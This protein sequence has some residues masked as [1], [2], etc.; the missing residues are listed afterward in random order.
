MIVAG[1]PAALRK[2]PV[3][4]GRIRRQANAAS[5]GA[6]AALIFDRWL[7][8]SLPG[9]S[10]KCHALAALVR[11]SPNKPYSFTITCRGTV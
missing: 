5:N 6:V 7:S 10:R 4:D 3:F 9:A 8:R 1:S 2:S 11:R